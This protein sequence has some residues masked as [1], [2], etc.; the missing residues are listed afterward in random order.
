MRSLHF[1]KFA[2]NES[3]FVLDLYYL[4]LSIMCKL[5]KIVHLNLAISYDLV[6]YKKKSFIIL[7]LDS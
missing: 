5:I 2:P 3:A 1:H 6:S 7:I 4:A